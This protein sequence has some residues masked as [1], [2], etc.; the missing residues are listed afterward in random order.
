MA[1]FGFSGLYNN[2]YQQPANYQEFNLMTGTNKVG[3]HMIVNGNYLNIRGSNN[4]LNGHHNTMIGENCTING[5]NNKV[6]GMRNK[7]I[8]NYNKVTGDDNQIKG[9]SNSYSGNNISINGKL[10]ASATMTITNNLN[11]NRTNTAHNIGVPFY[12]HKPKLQHMSNI[13]DVVLPG[14]DEIT[15]DHLLQCG[16][17]VT[18]KKAI[19][20]KCGHLFYC[21]ECFYKCEELNKDKCPLC[22]RVMEDPRIIFN[23]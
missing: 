22:N 8:G 7:I 19:A 13:F 20:P 15:E 4:I 14:T 23:N 10:F 9:T 1:F 16:A 21:R 2:R 18:N 17:C 11:T 3:E 12:Y 6:I 5:N